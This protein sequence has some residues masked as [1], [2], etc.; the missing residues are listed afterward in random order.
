[1][2]PLLMEYLAKNGYIVTEI[3]PGYERG[4]DIIASKTGRETVFE[5]KGDTT[6]PGVDLGTAIWQLLRYMKD[7]SRDF[8]LALTPKYLQYVNAVEYGLKK[9]NIKVFLVSESRIEQIY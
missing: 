3:H 4:P 1:M 7:N 9:L 6:E 8:A 5:V 2:F